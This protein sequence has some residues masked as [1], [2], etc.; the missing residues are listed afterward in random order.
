VYQILVN[1]IT[2]I[3]YFSKNE[4]RIERVYYDYR[5]GKYR[6]ETLKP[7]LKIEMFKL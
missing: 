2:L 7:S 6:W 3:E 4:Y 1:I 5:Y